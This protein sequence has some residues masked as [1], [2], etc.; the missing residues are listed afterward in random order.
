MTI[1]ACASLPY[2][3]NEKGQGDSVGAPKVFKFVPCGKCS[4]IMPCAK[5][6][7]CDTFKTHQIISAGGNNYDMWKEID[8]GGCKKLDFDGNELQLS[9][10]FDADGNPDPTFPQH[11]YRVKFD[12]DYIRSNPDCKNPFNEEN[13]PDLEP[14]DGNERSHPGCPA[15]AEQTGTAG[16]AARYTIRMTRSHAV[17][18]YELDEDGNPTT[19]PIVC[20]SQ[21][22]NEDGSDAGCVYEQL[23]SFACSEEGEPCDPTQSAPQGCECVCTPEFID[24]EICGYFVEPACGDN[25]VE[26]REI[27]PEDPAHVISNFTRGP[28]PFKGVGWAPSFAGY[29]YHIKKT[30]TVPSADPTTQAFTCERTETDC[31]E[32]ELVPDCVN[33]ISSCVQPMDS[34]GINVNQDLGTDPETGKKFV[35]PKH[36]QFN[37]SSLVYSAETETEDCNIPEMDCSKAYYY[38]NNWSSGGSACFNQVVQGTVGGRKQHYVNGDTPYGSEYIHPDGFPTRTSSDPDIDGTPFRS[39]GVR[40]KVDL[41]AENCNDN[42]RWGNNGKLGNASHPPT[43]RFGQ[44][45][46]CSP[47]ALW[48]EIQRDDLGTYD[49]KG[50]AIGEKRVYREACWFQGKGKARI[51]NSTRI[52]TEP[53]SVQLTAPDFQRTNSRFVEYFV[54]VEGLVPPVCDDGNVPCSGAGANLIKPLPCLPYAQNDKVDSDGVQGRPQAMRLEGGWVCKNQKYDVYYV[55]SRA[56]RMTDYFLWLCCQSFSCFCCRESC[57]PNACPPQCNCGGEG[58]GCPCD[59]C[60]ECRR[61]ALYACGAIGSGGNGYEDPGDGDGTIGG[62][63]GCPGGTTHNQ[64]GSFSDGCGNSGYKCVNIS[65]AVNLEHGATAP[66]PGSET[67]VPSYQGFKKDLYIRVLLRCDPEATHYDPLTGESSRGVIRSEL[68]LWSQKHPR[69]DDDGD[70]D[71]IPVSDGGATKGWEPVTGGPTATPCTLEDGGNDFCD[72]W[73]GFIYGDE[74]GAIPCESCYNIVLADRLYNEDPSLGYPPLASFCGCQGDDDIGTAWPCNGCEEGNTKCDDFNPGCLP[75]IFNH[76]WSEGLM[77]IK[78]VSGPTINEEGIGGSVPAGGP[79]NRSNYWRWGCDFVPTGYGLTPGR[80]SNWTGGLGSYPMP[81]PTKSSAAMFCR[82]DCNHI[83]ERCISP[84][85][86]CEGDCFCS[87]DQGG[88][89][90][91]NCQDDP[92]PELDCPDNEFTYQQKINTVNP[93]DRLSKVLGVMDIRT[94]SEWQIRTF[95]TG[96]TNGSSAFC[97]RHRYGFNKHLHPMFNLFGCN[98]TGLGK[99]FCDGSDEGDGGGIPPC[100]EVTGERGPAPMF[101]AYRELIDSYPNIEKMGIGGSQS[102]P[103]HFTSGMRNTTMQFAKPCTGWTKLVNELNY[104]VVPAG[105][106]TYKQG[107]GPGDLEDKDYGSDHENYTQPG[108]RSLS[109]SHAGSVD[110]PVGYATDRVDSE[111]TALPHC[112]YTDMIVAISGGAYEDIQP[113]ARQKADLGPAISE[114]FKLSYIFTKECDA[115]WYSID[116][117]HMK[118]QANGCAKKPTLTGGQVSFDFYDPTDQG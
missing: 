37:L 55:C 17:F 97:N 74:P 58:T 15:S 23:G 52:E 3:C 84:S 72:A 82:R 78:A 103:Q 116:S 40:C 65:S 11:V 118:H 89:T 91:P 26:T 83:E 38:E 32:S 30:R 68:T 10:E 29:K 112:T 81:D 22:V 101:P 36:L 48:E 8:G 94:T 54:D 113:D 79:I 111:G 39:R 115:N 41:E 25:T 12:S 51:I 99:S 57:E 6:F 106:Y 77:D 108:E 90:N 86:N 110:L 33:E 2:G 28:W 100:S 46:M 59:S 43:Q 13:C 104:P 20:E 50:E 85:C 70:S 49:D 53:V 47:F 67:S 80:F 93:G 24:Q 109:A 21:T 35:W 87:P 98:Y 34:F 9:T 1:R 62:V 96:S 5:E 88:N 18:G 69:Y 63:S 61:T 64:C 14:C 4:A 92:D 73:D 60:R 19:T 76:E 117:G 44:F 42:N 66:C 71:G 102:G 114:Q 16:F 95:G 105:Q 75:N 56:N 27:C 7:I 45:S 107:Y 31:G